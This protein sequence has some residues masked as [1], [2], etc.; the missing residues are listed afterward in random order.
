MI[1]F[2]SLNWSVFRLF[3]DRF[4]F[5]FEFFRVSFWSFLVEYVNQTIVVIAFNLTEFGVFF[6]LF[7]VV[8]F[9]F[10]FSFLESAKQLF[11]F[12]APL[13]SIVCLMQSVVFAIC[14][15]GSSVFK[16][17]NL[18][19]ILF[20]SWFL[21]LFVS[22]SFVESKYHVLN[23]QDTVLWIAALTSVIVAN[24]ALCFL[25]FKT[26]RKSCDLLI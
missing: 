19:S 20:N 24:V 4:C 17:I 26:F 22:V 3:R 14:S 9:W 21:F 6:D 18:F 8:C 2:L 15:Y 7:V 16:N 13:F 12:C 23:R 5:C 25:S 11:F 1:C 10:W